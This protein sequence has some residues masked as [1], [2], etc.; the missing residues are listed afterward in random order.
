MKDISIY[1]NPVEYSGEFAT[2]QLGSFIE[3]FDKAGFPMIGD[4]GVAIISVP[5]NRNGIDQ[6]EYTDSNIREQF[7]QMNVGDAWSR[8]IYDLGTINP[9][10]EVKDTYF[11]LA[12]VV[13]ELIKKDVI[14]IVL[15]GSQDLTM[16]CYRGFEALEQTINICAIDHKLDIGD[17][18]KEIAADGYVSHLLMQRPCYLFNYATIGIQRP[19][20]S[21]EYLDLFDKLY[22]DYVRLGQFQDD[23]KVAEPHLR[24]SDMLTV[25]LN[26]VRRSDIGTAYPQVNGFRADQIC[27]IGKYAGMS[28]KMSCIGVFNIQSQGDRPSFDLIAEFMWYFIDGVNTRVGDFPIGSKQGYKKFYAHLENFEDDLVFYKSNKSDRWWLEIKHPSGDK[29]KYDRHHMVP[30][31]KED[32]DKA[33]KN[34]IPDLWW[35]TLQKLG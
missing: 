31:T 8:P 9:G 12:Q 2:H 15:G 19:Y 23:F 21:G 16:A 1:L 22:F 17:P 20:V 26:A 3:K 25:D 5:E 13:S 11:A 30:C 35:K 24:N 10:H 32:Y 34:I 33:M 29:S 6:G 28:D 14:P 27:Q 7:Y 4:E 18:A